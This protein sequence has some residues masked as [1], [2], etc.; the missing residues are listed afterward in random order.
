MPVK[1]KNSIVT[2]EAKMTFAR[3]FFL[4]FC[5]ILA[6]NILG[7]EFYTFVDDKCRAHSGLIT[8]INEQNFFLWKLDGK[9]ISL[10]REKISSVLVFDTR[11]NPYSNVKSSPKLRPFLRK[12][13]FGTSNDRE[14]IIGWPYKFVEDLVFYISTQN[15]N[16]V[17]S[18]EQIKSIQGLA[19]NERVSDSKDR[20]FPVVLNLAPYL[21][22]CFPNR[23]SRAAGLRPT[24]T[25]TDKIKVFVFFENLENGLNRVSNFEDRTQVYARP[26]LYGK[27]DARFGIQRFDE[28]RREL[29]M[30]S[31]P[32][33]PVYFQWKS[34]SDFH[35]QSQ[36][37]LGGSYQQW[38]PNV[39]P[40]SVIASD[41]KSHFFNALFIGNLTTLS[42]GRPLKLGGTG[43]APE[44]YNVS[45]SL[46]YMALMGFDYHK[47]TFA[48]GPYYPIYNLS[49]EDSTTQVLAVKASPAF[50]F[51]YTGE[52][53]KL[54]LLVSRTSYDQNNP[55][56]ADVIDEAGNP[57][58][59]DHFSLKA[60]TLRA[61]FDYQINADMIASI[62]EVLTFGKYKSRGDSVNVEFDFRHLYTTASLQRDMGDY[63]FL[64]LT[65][66]YYI[67]KYKN[68]ITG[69]AGGNVDDSHD[70]TDFKFGVVFG[71][72][73]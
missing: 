68:K 6:N 23:P 17:L 5:L 26:F 54:R 45:T 72:I 43:G 40:L 55:S 11:K 37:T 24:R 19:P 36:T 15:K 30:H 66:N 71:L 52:K 28:Q 7:Y 22:H 48:V 73:F 57:D 53:S 33:L 51:Q 8:G 4:V 56:A 34:G 69:L 50:R 46:N 3:L 12:V 21:P 27:N 20:T 65:G 14:S 2:V 67:Y 59:G 60:H 42:A 62:D 49:T 1:Y 18:L 64:R 63:V 39:E 41:L 38:L 32:V 10:Q 58:G 31:S 61:G 9:L 29:Y 16:Y 70:G 44:K 35:F 47:Y 25:I 13:T